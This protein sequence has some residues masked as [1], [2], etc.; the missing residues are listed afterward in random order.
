MGLRDHQ[1]VMRSISSAL[2][3]GARQ[4][5]IARYELDA[6]G[7]CE[8]PV[9]FGMEGR[10]SAALEHVD[11]VLVTPRTVVLDS[12][13]KSGKPTPATLLLDGFGRCRRCGNCLDARRREWSVRARQECNLAIRNWFTTFT[14]TPERQFYYLE[15]ARRHAALSGVDLDAENDIERFRRHARAIGRELTLALKRLRKVVKTELRYI[16]VFEAHRSG[17]PHIHGIIHEC[18]RL[19]SVRKVDIQDCWHVGFSQAKL[20]DAKTA[21][22]ITKYLAKDMRTRV[23]ASVGYGQR[24]VNAAERTPAATTYDPS[25]ALI[26]PKRGSTDPKESNALR[27]DPKEATA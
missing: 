10:P 16:F 7:D 25:E 11:G 9:G 5:T 3:H 13:L 12:G 18:D 19:G 20:C 17:N 22:Y 1:S 14:L 6:A 23:R 27:T 8:N 21:Y 26:L 24:I 4:K 2:D 15:V